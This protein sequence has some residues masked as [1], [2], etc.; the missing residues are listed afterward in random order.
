[1]KFPVHQISGILFSPLFELPMKKMMRGPT[2]VEHEVQP[3]PWLIVVGEQRC[4]LDSPPFRSFRR[5]SRPGSTVHVSVRSLVQLAS[6]GTQS[7]AV[8]DE[9]RFLYSRMSEQPV[10]VPPSD[11][12][13]RFFIFKYVYVEFLCAI[14][15]PFSTN[16]L[17]KVRCFNEWISVPSRG[18][19]T[20]LRIF[21]NTSGRGNSIIGYQLSKFFESFNHFLGEF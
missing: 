19:L 17:K 20:W 5:S 4:K 3:G 9:A 18:Y 1:M 6:H 16:L 15:S 11:V 12:F 10:R 7:V 2:R 13:R 8:T 14:S 21:R